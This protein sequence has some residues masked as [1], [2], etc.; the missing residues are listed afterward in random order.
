MLQEIS[1]ESH[2][3]KYD[4]TNTTPIEDDNIIYKDDITWMNLHELESNVSKVA[5][6]GEN[7]SR[8]IKLLFG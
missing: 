2:L 6:Y 1:I 4:I 7:V 8:I 5:F 3:G